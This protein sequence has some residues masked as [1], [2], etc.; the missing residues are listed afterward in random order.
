MG[1]IIS[2][3]VRDKGCAAK[4]RGSLLRGKSSPPEHKHGTR[5]KIVAQA[6]LQTQ[7]IL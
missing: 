7:H 4:F 3:V 5:Q 2:L 1:N 6:T